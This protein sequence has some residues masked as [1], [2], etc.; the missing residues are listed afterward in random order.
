MNLYTDDRF[1]EN[2][3]SNNLV[4]IWVIQPYHRFYEGLNFKFLFNRPRDLRGQT[5][6]HKDHNKMDPTCSVLTRKITKNSQTE[7]CFDSFRPRSAGIFNPILC[8]LCNKP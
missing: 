1:A 6:V 7:K 8:C 4:E 3:I 2:K 5:V